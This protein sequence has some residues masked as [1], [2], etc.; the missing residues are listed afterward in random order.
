[1]EVQGS[2]L[3]QLDAALGSTFEETRPCFVDNA[4]SSSTSVSLTAVFDAKGALENFKLESPTQKKTSAA[5]LSAIKKRDG[6]TGPAGE[7]IICSR[8]CG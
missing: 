3:N 4:V 2:E 5:C 7:T 1:M 6:I 8:Y